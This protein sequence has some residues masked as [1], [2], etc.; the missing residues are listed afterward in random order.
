MLSQEFLKHPIDLIKDFFQSKKALE[1]M[2]ALLP[3]S[4]ERKVIFED[5][6][7]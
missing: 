1:P 4:P 5:F 3:M 6:L 7:K 2:A